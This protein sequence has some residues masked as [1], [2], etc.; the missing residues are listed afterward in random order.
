MKQVQCQGPTY[1]RRQ[2]AK[3]FSPWQPGAR[4]LRTSCV[5]ERFFVAVRSGREGKR[6][7]SKTNCLRQ[8]SRILT[9]I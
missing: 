4:D 2:H 5:L 1:T 6:Q 8:E 7:A 9:G 3:F